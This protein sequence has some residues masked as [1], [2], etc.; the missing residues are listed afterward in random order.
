MYSFSETIK[1]FFS[2]IMGKTRQ[3]K[4]QGKKQGTNHRGLMKDVHR[5][6]LCTRHIKK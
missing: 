3:R 4:T 6:Q 5:W 2:K 1:L